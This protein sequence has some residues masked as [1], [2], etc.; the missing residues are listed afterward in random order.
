MGG[1]NVMFT[2]IIAVQSRFY[3]IAQVS[4]I[5]SSGTAVLTCMGHDKPPCMTLASRSVLPYTTAHVNIEIETTQEGGDMM[6]GVTPLNAKS[7]PTTCQW[8]LSTG[9]STHPAP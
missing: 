3:R 7:P 8:N 6:M 9:C 1:G 2:A 5:F 4:R